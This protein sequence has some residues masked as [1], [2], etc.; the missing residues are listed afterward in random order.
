MHCALSSLIWALFL[1]NQR[2]SRKH[3]TLLSPNILGSPPSLM[4]LAMLAKIIQLLNQKHCTALVPGERLSK[5]KPPRQSLSFWSEVLITPNTGLK[6]AHYIDISSHFLT[7]M[8]L[9]HMRK[10]LLKKSMSAAGTFFFVN[11]LQGWLSV[12]F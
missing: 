10:A 5:E 6:P 2:K 1:A 7:S 3:F 11:N 9:S 4:P 12:Q 8:T